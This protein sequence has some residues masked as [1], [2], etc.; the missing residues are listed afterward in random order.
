[1]I[2]ASLLEESNFPEFYDCEF[3]VKLYSLHY[4]LLYLL[5]DGTSTWPP[6]D[7]HTTS[8]RQ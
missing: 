2:P 1:M 6:A 4:I 3:L 7:C 8:V 5:T